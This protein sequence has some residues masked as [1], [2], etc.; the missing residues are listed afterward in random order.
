[1]AMEIIFKSEQD[2]QIVKQVQTT[3]DGTNL[4]QV[5]LGDTVVKFGAQVITN[6]IT[7]NQI[8]GIED[9]KDEKIIEFLDRSEFFYQPAQ[10]EMELALTGD[11]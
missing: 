11:Q 9:S 4:T 1:M 8:K 6:I 5:N 10:I 7:T 3:P 2:K